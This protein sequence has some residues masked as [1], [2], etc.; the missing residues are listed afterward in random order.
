[1][2]LIRFKYYSAWKIGILSVHI[3]HLSYNPA[4]QD[5]TKIDHCKVAIIEGSP[6]IREKIGNWNIMVQEWLRKCVYERV[7]FKSRFAKQLY[8]FMVSAFWHG[9][10]AGYYFS[11]FL[12]F[13]QVYVQAEIFRLFKNDNNPM[14]KICQ[15]LGKPLIIGMTILSCILF[16]HN[17]TFF[18]LLQT[19]YC[20]ELM[21]RVYYIPQLILVVAIIGFKAIPKKRAPKVHHG[22]KFLETKSS[23]GSS[24]GSGLGL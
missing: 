18:Y 8:V 22:N 2:T 6:H 21:R 14:V 12:W 23:S 4:T 24:V 19:K 3:S 1:M 16:S 17:A 11:F 7:G 15:K 5:Y 13:A 20:L 10:Y 9:F